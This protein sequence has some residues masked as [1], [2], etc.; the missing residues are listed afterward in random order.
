MKNKPNHKPAAWQKEQIIELL[1][2]SGKRITQQ[3]IIL[4]EII[5]EGSWSNCKE[6]YYQAVKKDS[7]I[8]MATVYRMLSTLE[9]L[10]VLTRSYQYSLPAA[11]KEQ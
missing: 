3:R 8:G 11:G 5:L 10:G 6:I 7:T 2:Q 9:E 1:Q 4:I